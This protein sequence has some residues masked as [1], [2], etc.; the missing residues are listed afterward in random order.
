MIKHML[1]TCDLGNS[2]IKIGIYENNVQLNFGMFPSN[3]D[4]FKGNILSLIYQIN[5]RADEVDDAIVASVVPNLTPILMA[6]LKSI[7]NKDPILIDAY[8]IKG[9]ELNHINKDEVG[10]DLLVMSA[11]AYQKYQKDIILISF[12]TCTVFV[13]IT[14][15]GELRHCIICPGFDAMASTLYKNAAKLPEIQLSKNDSFLQKDT[16]GAMK[17]GIYDGYI[18]MCKYLLENMKNEINDDSTVVA[19][20]GYAN[21]VAN[22][23]DGVEHIEPDYVTSGLNFLYNTYYHE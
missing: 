5:R 18:G 22:Y 23:L 16:V 11:Y 21:D 13:H 2:Q 3:Q 9:I 19:C 8:N 6:D 15:D 1:I 7:I 10:A 12:G 17:V 14:S 20:G 4:S